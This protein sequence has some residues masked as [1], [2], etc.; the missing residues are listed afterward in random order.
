MK[1]LNEIKSMLVPHHDCVANESQP[2]SNFCRFLR[3]DADV[4]SGDDDDLLLTMQTQAVHIDR[5]AEDSDHQPSDHQ[6]DD[7]ADIG[8]SQYYEF[9]SV[10]CLKITENMQEI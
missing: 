7:E 1:V 2:C 3:N 9:H 4:E 10:L 6:S 8:M 5:H